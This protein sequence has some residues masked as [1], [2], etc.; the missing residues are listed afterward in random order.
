MSYFSNVYLHFFSVGGQ[1]GNVN[2]C[3][4]SLRDGFRGTFRNVGL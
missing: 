4:E 3:G 2:F 1:C